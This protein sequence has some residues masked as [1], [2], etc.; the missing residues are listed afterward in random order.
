MDLDV[1]T[2]RFSGALPATRYDL[3]PVIVTPIWKEWALFDGETLVVAESVGAADYFLAP[4]ETDL[5][6][7]HMRRPLPPSAFDGLDPD[8]ILLG[9]GEGVHEDA[10]ATLDETL[11]NARATTLAF[12]RENAPTMVR[13]LTAA[14]TTE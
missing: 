5:G 7:S 1:P 2:R 13:T 9:H 12:Y 6:V 3:L 14:L 10:A 11:A 8:R 4:E